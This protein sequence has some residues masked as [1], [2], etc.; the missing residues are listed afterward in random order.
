MVQSVFISPLL[1]PHKMTPDQLNNAYTVARQALLDERQDRPYWEG[2]LSASALSTA[3]AVSALALYQQA[4]ADDQQQEEVV[5]P[6]ACTPL[7][8]GGIR[9]LRNHQ[10]QD[11]GGGDTD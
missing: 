2:E 7:I 1:V 4:S 5:D 8:D 3:T 10:N 11:G 6:A 9:W